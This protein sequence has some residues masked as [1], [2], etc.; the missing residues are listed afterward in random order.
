MMLTELWSERLLLTFREE[1]VYEKFEKSAR[2]I[3]E[4]SDELLSSFAEEH[5]NDP[6]PQQKQ[7]ESCEERVEHPTRRSGNLVAERRPKDNRERY[8]RDP[9]SGPEVQ[10]RS[11]FREF[12][13]AAS[14]TVPGGKQIDM[15]FRAD[16]FAECPTT[17]PAVHASGGPYLAAVEAEDHENAPGG[18]MPRS[19]NVQTRKSKPCCPITRFRLDARC[20]PVV[21]VRTCIAISP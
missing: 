17:F 4:T 11:P 9:R 12:W 5:N 20:I 1:N 15:P 10:R 2:Q 3:P 16:T 8:D 19:S 18:V 21:T 6:A 7:E 13:G 14:R